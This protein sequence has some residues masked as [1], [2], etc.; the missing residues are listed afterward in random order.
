[1]PIL[2]LGLHIIIA[3]FFAV[4]AVRSGQDRYWLFILFMFPLLGSVVYG[5]A[6]W[7][8]DARRSRGARALVRNVKAALDP[9]RELREAREAFDIAQTAANRLRLAD[10]LVAAGEPADA[11]EQYESVLRG[12]H[13]D[14][15]SV[16]VRLAQAMLDANKPYEARELLATLIREQPDFRS[17][18]GHLTYACAVAETGERD[19]ARHEFDILIDYY[20][21]MEARARYA[22]YLWSWGEHDDARAL[23]EKSLMLAQRMPKHSRQMSKPWIE[24]LQRIAARSQQ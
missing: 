21:G 10:A 1:M 9:G 12:V 11:I 8:P 19:A 23:A 13:K 16:Q 20:A 22:Q 5:F 17:S 14:D 2:G 4:H 7:L 3:L 18:E 15:A 6:I 24:R